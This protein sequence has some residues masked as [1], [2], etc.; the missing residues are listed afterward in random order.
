[1][2][3]LVR[4][5]L[6]CTG[7]KLAQAVLRENDPVQVLRDGSLAVDVRSYQD[8]EQYCRDNCITTFLKK[9]DDG[10][11]RADH[12]ADA[13]N[14]F[15]A[16]EEKNQLTN[17]R[18]IN[19]E[20]GYF[21]NTDELAHWDLIQVARRKIKR[22]LGAAPKWDE[23]NWKHGPGTAIGFSGR[24]ASL[25]KK[26]STTRTTVSSVLLAEADF[27]LEFLNP[28]AI[29]YF[30]VTDYNRFSTVPKDCKKRRLIAV[31][32]LANMAFQLGLGRV[33]RSRLNRMG[34]LL[35]DAQATHNR[36]AQNASITKHL[37]TLDL[38]NA[39]DLVSLE[40]VRAL[41]PPDWFRMLIACRS[42][43]TSVDGQM[44]TLH[45]FSSMGNGYTF[46]LETLIFYA[47]AAACCGS[48][49]SV[50]VYGDDT[51]IPDS[52]A[53][54]LIK[55]LEFSGLEVN[56][57]KSFSG[58]C[59]FRESCGGDFFEGLPV[60]GIYLKRMPKEPSDW[61]ALAN[62]VRRYA[63]QIG[64]LSK[65]GYMPLWSYC[66]SQIP[67]RLRF[68]GPEHLG[69]LVLH[70]EDWVPK[71]RKIVKDDFGGLF[72]MVK[73]ILPLIRKHRWAEDDKRY[74]FYHYAGVT[75]LD[76]EAIKDFYSTRSDD[77]VGYKVSWLHTTRQSD[78]MS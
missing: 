33:M 57:S 15:F 16:L 20:A 74:L 22:I 60:R 70:T 68:S 40:L 49:E 61:I 48:A 8:A 12:I 66:V 65:T 78:R 24:E 52:Y 71:L 67:R 36:L 53:D 41:I 63:L 26:L 37:A 3:N 30:C 51:I 32:P 47:L 72:P 9:L 28:L 4:I 17:R 69:D 5:L 55:L 45:K 46:E 58:Q 18:F 34:L 14:L 21:R 10:V 62:Q 56:Q 59:S 38:S 1:M 31:E 2:Q 73:G 42:P 43:Q 11:T 50:S 25:I 75:G 7:T 44:Y 64:P 54:A 19:Y 76:W 6:E 13:K 27:S 77:V 35:E 29:Q 23:I 39:S